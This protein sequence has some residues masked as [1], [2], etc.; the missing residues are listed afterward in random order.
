M[1]TEAQAIYDITQQLSQAYAAD[2]QR[3]CQRLCEH[4]DHCLVRHGL[5]LTEPVTLGTAVAGYHDS[6][7]R[8]L[9][10]AS[11]ANWLSTAG[12]LHL[13][14]TTPPYTQEAHPA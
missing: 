5:P 13:S 11:L 9:A 8:L 12:Y 3:L 7:A 4:L 1:Q 2:F 14:T 10:M 6:S